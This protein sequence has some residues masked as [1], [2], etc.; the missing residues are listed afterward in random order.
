M[1]LKHFSRGGV[2]SGIVDCLHLDYFSQIELTQQRAFFWQEAHAQG[3]GG[4]IVCESD[5]LDN[6]GQ[7]VDAPSERLV[8]QDIHDHIRIDLPNTVTHLTGQSQNRFQFFWVPSF[9]QPFKLSSRLQK[10]SKISCHH[11]CWAFLGGSW[12]GKKICNFLI[13]FIALQQ[14]HLS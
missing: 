14:F 12:E 2:F 13:N 11:I 4:I 1:L 6:E 7:F 8:L 5:D 9:C 10:P 3:D